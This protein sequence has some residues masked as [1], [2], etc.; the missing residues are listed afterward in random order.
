MKNVLQRAVNNP[1]KTIHVPDNA[2]DL[3]KVIFHELGYF[4]DAYE[5]YGNIKSLYDLTYSSSSKFINAYREDLMENWTNIQNNT[6]L[7]LCIL[8]STPKRINQTAIIET[9]AE[10]FRYLYTREN[11]YI[12]TFFANSINTYKDFGLPFPD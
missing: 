3:K 11:S 4:L 2:K 8:N 6:E 5:K 7:E 10:I 1:Y 12:E 9:F